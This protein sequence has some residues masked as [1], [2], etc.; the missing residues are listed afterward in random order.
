MTTAMVFGGFGVAAS[1]SKSVFGNGCRRIGTER[2]RRKLPVV[3]R[4]VGNAERVMDEHLVVALRDAH[5]REDCA[6]RIRPQQQIDL[7]DGD[8]L[9]VERAREVRLRLV[10]L[11]DPLDRPAEQAAARDSAA[12]R[13]SRRRAGGRA[14]SRRAAR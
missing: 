10:V 2:P 4:E 11:D 12:R 6:G 7:V 5:G 13:R 9:L 8:E 14:R 1:A 3:L